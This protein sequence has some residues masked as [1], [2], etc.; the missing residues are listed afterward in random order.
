[1]I[2]SAPSG[3]G[4][5]STATVAFHGSAED[6]ND[7][8]IAFSC[9]V[10]GAAPVPCASPD[11]L[12]G[13]ADG[14]HTISIS[15]EDDVGNTSVT[16]ATATWTVGGSGSGVSSVPPESTVRDAGVGVGL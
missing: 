12:T 7:A 6:G 1:M 3:V 2:D 11:V 9:S 14:V 8:A 16:P 5:E 15:A 13:L 4:K 10:D